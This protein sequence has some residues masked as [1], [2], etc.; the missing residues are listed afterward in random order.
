[1]VL[2]TTFMPTI[3]T[4][5]LYNISIKW[6]DFVLASK[7]N[8]VSLEVPFFIACF[9]S[10]VARSNHDAILSWSHGTSAASAWTRR[11]NF[12]C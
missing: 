12:G 5:G 4:M 11:D 6:F 8:V 3:A 2:M 7:T 1:M 10:T 9:V